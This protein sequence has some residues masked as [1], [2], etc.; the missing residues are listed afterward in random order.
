LPGDFLDIVENSLPGRSAGKAVQQVAQALGADATR[1]AAAAGFPGR[2]P[3]VLAEGF[4][5]A[6]IAVEDQE[7][8]VGDE[9]LGC[10]A[11]RETVQVVRDVRCR[12]GLP[13]TEVMNLP[14][15]DAIYRVAHRV[16]PQ[17]IIQKIIVT[18]QV[19]SFFSFPFAP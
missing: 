9:G 8:A 3:Q 13:G 4:D 2:L 18:V 14:V 11:W 19:P 12:A 16:S 7:A 6:C 17:P 15:P 1:R 5:Q 10:V